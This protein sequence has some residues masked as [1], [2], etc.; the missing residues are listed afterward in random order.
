MQRIF[1][2]SVFA[3]LGLFAALIIAIIA[4]NLIPDERYKQW[5]I[6]ATYQKTQRE[7]SIDALQI[8]FGPTIHVKA[9]QILLENAPNSAKQ[10]MLSVAQFQAELN[11]L[12]FITKKTSWRSTLKTTI[13]H[14]NIHIE[15]TT[16][17]VSNWAVFDS[18]NTSKP[19]EKFS[20]L[21]LPHLDDIQIEDLTLNLGVKPQ[22]KTQ[23]LHIDSL[24]IKTPQ[25]DSEFS[26]IASINN[27]P[28]QLNGSLGDMHQFTQERSQPLNIEGDIDGSPIS[29]SG[30][31]GPLFPKQNMKLNL[32]FASLESEKLMSLA[33]LAPKALGSLSW[34]NTLVA[35]QSVYSIDALKANINGAEL[36][37]SIN[38][39]IQDLRT[40][41]GINLSL[42]AD[43]KKLEDMAR[44]FS[45]EQALPSNISV[46]T[47]I[48]GSREHLSASKLDLTIKDQGI[49]VNLTGKLDNLLTE[50]T[51][52]AH[53]NGVLDS[54]SNVSRFA[55]IEMP[56][57]GLVRLVG[58]LA[59]ANKSLQIENLQTSIE[60][61]NLN[62]K[63]NGRVN[64]ALELSGIDA[65]F[66]ADIDSL[67]KQN[68]TELEKLLAHFN[69]K[70]PKQF[71]PDNVHIHGKMKGHRKS[72]SLQ[73]VQ[74]TINDKGVKLTLTGEVNNLLQPT[75]VKADVTLVS[76]SLSNFE[77]YFQKQLPNTEPVTITATLQPQS[78]GETSFSVKATMSDIKA[79]ASGVLQDLKSP[80]NIALDFNIKANNLTDFS[81]FT[82]KKLPQLGPINASTK[83]LLGKK[84]FSAQQIKIAIDEHLASGNISLILPKDEKTITAIQ[85]KLTIARLDLTPWLPDLNKTSKEKEAPLK[86]KSN[87]QQY[88]DDAADADKVTDERLFSS[89]PILLEQLHNYDI[90]L[91][92]NIDQLIINETKLDQANI[93]ISL[94]Q[95]LLSIKPIQ[96]A[97]DKIKGY[98]VVDGRDEIPALDIDITVKQLPLPLLGGQLN[99]T[100]NAIGKGQSVAEL[101]GSVNGKILLVTRNGVIN[102]RLAKKIGAG[103][104][105]FSKDSNTTKL[106][107]GILRIDIKDGQA[108]FVKKLAAQFTEVTWLG[109][110]QIDLKTEK[111]QADISP[112]PRKG[113]PLSTTGSL[114]GLAYIAGTLKHP[115]IVLDPKD[116][117]VKYAKYSALV[118]TGGLSLLAEAAKN[119][120]Q[121][122]QDICQKI[123]DL[124]E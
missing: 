23:Q 106:E 55:N 39:S 31:W 28:I 69:V 123:L 62:I 89:K 120:I 44:K 110:G 9:G 90:D 43:T 118:A 10:N 41:K 6:D 5:L 92:L 59:L 97:D 63:L 47:H 57:L 4:L 103:L 119:K 100:I 33:G 107:C 20:T 7:L 101:M 70:L 65:N 79:Q 13:S 48:I 86:H 85:G 113:I 64:N 42:N 26:F 121:A 108:D 124:K 46:S 77:K 116:V 15:Q 38:G 102:N 25:R 84:Q 35:K 24:Q 71:L 52:T 54:L 58:D 60:S 51:L 8:E 17:G 93:D 22:T 88:V 81:A 36:N 75:V 29:L 83:L 40:L 95:G 11:L 21:W 109:G 76:D 16:E 32:N 98:L 104:F 34:S 78:S 115:K 99:L 122:N 117:V 30:D 19:V 2:Y 18:N 12:T 91:K 80:E 27:L 56:D 111:L 61:N 68:I 50:P 45:V 37:A 112:R 66:K 3:I 73:D 82:D 74:G 96:T 105:S 72:L 1:K 49:N 67:T 94:N 87:E 14:A 53:V 114:A